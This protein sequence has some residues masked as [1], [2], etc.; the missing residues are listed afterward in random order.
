MQ[1]TIVSNRGLAVASV[2]LAALI[3]C[4]SLFNHLRKESAGAAGESFATLQSDFSNANLSSGTPPTPVD[5]GPVETPGEETLSFFTAF[6]IDP[7]SED[8]AGPKYVVAGDVDQDGLLDLVSGWNESQPIQIHLQRRS[9]NGS[10]SFRTI[11][12]AGTTPTA[13]MGGLQLGFINEDEFPDVVVLVKATGFTTL[14]P[15]DNPADPPS[16]I[17]SL[18]GEVIVYFNPGSAAAVTSGDLWPE[19]TLMNPL[20]T[21]FDTDPDTGALIRTQWV[22]NQWPGNEEDFETHKTSPETG[23]YTDLAVANIDG[24]PG[25]E[26]ITA[27]NVG[28]CDNLGME[29]PF[30]LVDLWQNPGP[31]LSETAEEWGV[32]VPVGTIAGFAADIRVPLSLMASLPQVND[33]E[34]FDVDDDG[35]LDVVATYTNAISLNIRWARNPLIPHQP[36]GASGVDAVYAGFDAAPIYFHSEWEQRPIG[37]LDSGA[38]RMALGDI[39]GDG[40]TDVLV[41][42]TEGQIVQWFRRPTSEDIPPEFP[43]N[44]PPTPDRFN[45]PWPV[46]TLTEFEERTPEGVTIG[47]VDGDSRPEVIIAAGGAVLWFDESSTLTPFDPWLENTIIKDVA[48][49]GFVSGGTTG[50][51]TGGSGGTANANA[52]SSTNANTSTPGGSGVGVG[53]VDTSTSINALLVVDLDGDGFN[54]IIGTLDRRTGAGLSDDRLVWYRNTLGDE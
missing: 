24:V 41:R 28:A 31:G 38:D 53:A 4:S 20:V 54:D 14:C 51:T 12:L 46:Y 18:E 13:I 23:G 36:D 30:T 34:V 47:D 11:T 50:G 1:N 27:L 39:D 35:D 29:P 40:F 22:H 17:S 25:D 43:P 9:D 21:R 5:P 49:G 6:Q 15:P 3:G 33:L 7:E 42:S 37:E 16:V 32:L 10:I 52:S 2:I 26:I 44:N 48:S 8:T 19:M 45:F